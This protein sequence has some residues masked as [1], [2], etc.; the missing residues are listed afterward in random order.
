[1]IR[2]MLL[3]GDGEIRMGAED[4]IAVWRQGGHTRIWIDIEDEKPEAEAALLRS[5][6][7]HELVIQDAQRAVHPPKIEEFSDRTFILYRGIASF[8]PTLELQAQTLAMFVMPDMLITRHPHSAVSVGKLYS[9]Q[10]VDLIRHGTG[11]L[12][13]KIML[14]SSGLYLEALLEFETELSEIEDALLKQGS[15]ELMSKLVTYRS[16]LVKLRRMFSYHKNITEELLSD[17]YVSL[18][19]SEEAMRHAITDLHDRFDRLY[20]LT[21]MFYSICGD[22]IDGYL[23]ITSHQLNQA[24]RVLTVITAIF[25]PLGFLAGLYGMNFDYIPELHIQGGYFILLAVMGS[26]AV[27]LLA[28]FRKIRWL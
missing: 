2:T 25:V 6:G 16:R 8:T 12:A 11:F 4:L 7:C 14:V 5:L 10:G 20:T 22:L 9:D 17:D 15:D 26:V 1:M 21:E 18:P 27:G 19:Q 3:T 13:L 28:L 24:M 23:S